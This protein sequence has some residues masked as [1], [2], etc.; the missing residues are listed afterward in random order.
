MKFTT[1][2]Y[3]AF[4]IVVVSSWAPT[5]AIVEEEKVICYAKELSPCEPAAQTGSKPTTECCKKLKE[6]ESC[7]CGYA[8]TYRKYISYE[9]ARKILE[10]CAIPI[11]TC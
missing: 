1:L 2:I 10:A 5:K 7:L 8:K 4:V 6:Q 3:I 9:G 11:P